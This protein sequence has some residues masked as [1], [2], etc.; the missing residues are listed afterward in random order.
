MTRPHI[1]DFKRYRPSR[2]I[3]RMCY[4]ISHIRI[5][6]TVADF[7]ILVAIIGVIDGG[8]GYVGVAF[9]FVTDRFW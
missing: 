6:L 3:S 8:V 5:M 2:H 1:H 9:P 7:V 4:N